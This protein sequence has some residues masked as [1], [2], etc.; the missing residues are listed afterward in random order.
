M[1]SALAVATVTGALLFYQRSAEW[2]RWMFFILILFAAGGYVGFTL[3]NGYL[4]FISDGWLEALWFLGVCAFIITAL[5]V[6]HPF[7]GYFS[8]RNYRVWLSMAALFILTGALVNTWVS[9]IF[10]Y[11]ILVLVFAAGLLIGFLVQNYLFSYWPR[12]A[13]LPYVPLIVLVF[14]S[15]AILL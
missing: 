3:S 8:R 5:M 10:T 6:Y 7:Y 9:V 4:S 2:E 11:I 15:V 13:W 14:A 1:L 12:F